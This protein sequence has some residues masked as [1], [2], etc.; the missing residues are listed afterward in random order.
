MNT[1][2]YKILASENTPRFGKPDPEEPRFAI[3]VE[4]MWTEFETPTSEKIKDYLNSHPNP[5]K[6]LY[7]LKLD[8]YTDEIVFKLYDQNEQYKN[9]GEALANVI[10]VLN[11]VEYN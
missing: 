1:I 11:Q 10:E 7:K 4:N 3:I 6:G 9:L 5:F 2:H 8:E